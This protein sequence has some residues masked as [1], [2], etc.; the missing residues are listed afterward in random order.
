MYKDLVDYK[1]I[2][3]K[4]KIYEG[5]I[6]NASPKNIA[7]L[8][9]GAYAHKELNGKIIDFKDLVN[10]KHSLY[11]DNGHGTHI[12]GII[13]AKKQGINLNCKQIV[14]KVLD[15]NGN[16]KV[17]NVIK[18]IEYILKRKDQLNIGIVNISM[19]AEAEQE[20]E[21]EKML[22]KYVESLWEKGLVVV[23]AGGNNGPKKQSI[24]VPGNSQKVITV[25]ACDDEV[26]STAGR[27]NYSG[28]GP[29][30]NCVI[31]PDIVTVGSNIFNLSNKNNGYI[32]R[33]GT[34]MATAVTT[35]VIGTI[36]E[37]NNEHTPKII[38]KML[39]DSALDM[40][41][42]VSVQGNGLL[43]IDKLYIF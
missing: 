12:S 15:K 18:G 25:G 6:I 1:Y 21:E 28:R 42:D 7:V 41:K 20:S 36:M 30:C 2:M 4:S 27:I 14:V 32:I 11:D 38:K 8:D 17:E 31:K 37:K 13:S 9:T 40:G 5:R 3:S 22:L 39:L 33:S 26:K 43:N 29:L 35:A 10:D 34:S 24:T 23:C 16:G 19:G